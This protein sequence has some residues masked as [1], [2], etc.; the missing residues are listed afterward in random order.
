MSD[1][2]LLLTTVPSTEAGET[3][4][5]NLVEARL[6]ACVNVLPAMTSIYRWKGAVEHDTEHQL[7]IKTVRNRVGEIEQRIRALHPYEL[8]ECLVVAADGGSTAYLTWVAESA[9]E[10]V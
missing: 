2:V 5:R 9:R 4:A 10:G 1:V 7:I 6:A 8:P 3:I